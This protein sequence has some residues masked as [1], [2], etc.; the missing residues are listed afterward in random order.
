MWK[1]L[2]VPE[3]LSLVE[4]LPR[5]L[6]QRIGNRNARSGNNTVFT[7]PT[8]PRDYLDVTAIQEISLDGRCERMKS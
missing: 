5:G 7:V 2:L 3:L 1:V 8:F 4:C 6:V